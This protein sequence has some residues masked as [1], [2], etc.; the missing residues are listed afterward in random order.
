MALRLKDASVQLTGLRPELLFALI[1]ADQVYTEAGAE[2]TTVTSVNDG[3]HSHTSLHYAG[4]AADLRIRDPYT[5][6]SVFDGRTPEQVAGAIR[7]RL[8]IDYDVILESTHIH[9]ER[10]E[11]RR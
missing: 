2:F 3:E 11:K 8:G 5:G 6:E 9:I 10:Q 7:D 4:A 1:V